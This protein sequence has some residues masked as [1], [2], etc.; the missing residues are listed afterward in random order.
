MVVNV[1]EGDDVVREFVQDHALSLPVLR[2]PKGRLW[3]QSDGRG[4]P[5]NLFW[6]SEGRKTD[7]GPKTEKEWRGILAAQGC[8]TDPI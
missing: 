7:V 8:A 4:L 1:G 6:S 3:R 2:D 5:A